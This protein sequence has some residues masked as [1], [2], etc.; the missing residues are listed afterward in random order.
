MM[1]SILTFSST[2]VAY[3]GLVCFVMTILGFT[4]SRNDSFE[5]KTEHNLFAVLTVLVITTIAA[6]CARRI[7]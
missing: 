3:T 1:I 2:G 6:T 4:L 5:L 7:P